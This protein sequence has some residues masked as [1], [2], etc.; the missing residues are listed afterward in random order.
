MKKPQRWLTRWAKQSVEEQEAIS[1]EETKE[2]NRGRKEQ[3]ILSMYE[4]NELLKQKWPSVKRVLSVRRIRTEKDQT[5]DVIHYY[6]TS[7][8][9]AKA[10]SYLKLIRK[11][12]WVENKLHYVKDVILAEDRTKFANYDRTKKNALYRNIVFNC[13]KFSGR[14]SIKYTLEKCAG[15]INLILELFRT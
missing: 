6:V 11:H 4:P 12:W 7:I 10:S 5:T 14:K 2:K 15:D 9:Q 8:K 13:I 3:R 1:T